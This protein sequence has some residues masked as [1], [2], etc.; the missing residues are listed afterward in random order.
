[1]SKSKPSK[2]RRHL[3]RAKRREIARSLRVRLHLCGNV[4]KYALE[5]A[6]TNDLGILHRMV[7]D[8][9]A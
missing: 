8:W 3:E 7:R 9:G 1:M 6:N 5:M 4:P 2:H